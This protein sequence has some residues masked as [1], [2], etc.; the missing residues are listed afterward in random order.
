[1]RP[2][3]ASAEDYIRI[4][5]SQVQPADHRAGHDHDLIGQAIHDAAGDRVAGLRCGEHHR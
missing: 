3:H 2:E 1:V 5:S 4:A